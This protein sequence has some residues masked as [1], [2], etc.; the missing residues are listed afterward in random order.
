MNHI[1]S[2]SMFRKSEFK[3]LQCSFQGI[4][5]RIVWKQIWGGA[6]GGGLIVLMV[7]AP[8]SNL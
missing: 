6:G 5:L 7:N 2:F 4:H 8:Y 3:S 1:F